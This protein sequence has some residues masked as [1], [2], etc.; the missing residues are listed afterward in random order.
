MF[1]DD[2]P[3]PNEPNEYAPTDWDAQVALVWAT[4]DQYTDDE[5]VAVI[6]TLAAERGAL[7]AA[8]LFERASARDYVGLEADAAPLYRAALELGLDDIRRPQAVI[9]LASTLRNLG[10][11]AEAVALL[12]NQLEADPESRWAAPTAAFLALALS[13][14][15]RE[16]EATAVALA[17]L[18][19][20][21]PAYSNAV[22]RYATEL[23]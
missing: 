7:D 15:G 19:S 4:T 10:E 1:D 11:S 17:A 22:R 20:F 6:D 23:R 12:E 13:S 9:Q 21:L 3:A 18:A 16:R 8:A 14:D 5:V 2:A